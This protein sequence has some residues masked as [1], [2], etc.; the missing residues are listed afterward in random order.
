MSELF[1][2]VPKRKVVP[3]GRNSPAPPRPGELARGSSWALLQRDGGYVLHFM[4]GAVGGLSK[5]ISLSEA[6]A[7]AIRAGGDA[8]AEQVI[9]IHGGG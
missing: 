5:D 8:A 6:E 7:E 4:S 1:K 2:G 3:D 9:A